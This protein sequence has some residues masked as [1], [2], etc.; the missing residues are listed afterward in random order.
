MRTKKSAEELKSMFD[1]TGKVAVVTGGSG[2]AGKAISI[3][4]ALYGAARSSRPAISEK[5]SAFI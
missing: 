4:L 2:G 5:S 1:L 3:G